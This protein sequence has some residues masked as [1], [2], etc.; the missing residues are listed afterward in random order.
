MANAGV[1]AGLVFLGYEI[2]QNT[3]QLRA[4]AS[5]AISESMNSMNAGIY[6]DASL[7]CGPLIFCYVWA[8]SLNE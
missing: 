8:R 6:N 5:R 7:A 2:R 4:D 1:V 3:V